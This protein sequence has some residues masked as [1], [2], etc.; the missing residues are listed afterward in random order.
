MT[1]IHENKFAFNVGNLQKGDILVFNTYHPS[2]NEK[3][4]SRYI[5]SALY[6][7][8]AFLL[9][10]DGFGVARNHIY[11]YGF[12]EIEDAVVL[13]VKNLSAEQV[14]EVI[15]VA[16]TKLGT[17]YGTLE[18]YRSLRY[19]ETDEQEHENRMFCSRLIA[20]S[21]EF[22]GVMLVPNPNYC[23]PKDFINSDKVEI[24]PDI[25]EETDA[26]LRKLIEKKAKEREDGDTVLALALLLQELREF[27][28]EDIQNMNQLNVVASKHPEKD[29]ECIQI[30]ESAQFFQYKALFYKVHPWTM[31][32]EDF[33]QHFSKTDDR[34]WFLRN[35]ISHIEKSYLPTF[36]NNIEVY[37]QLIKLFPQSGYMRYMYDGYSADVA[38]AKE[39][40]QRMYELMYFTIDEDQEGS[41]IFLDDLAT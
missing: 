28:G 16:G 31:T 2:L 38:E 1:E 8:D 21:F 11:S 37:S 17:E 35:Q 22:V 14:D 39:I 34:L 10:S 25:L 33:K 26:D 3:M 7:G 30:I 40:L 5:H 36:E 13:R 27:Y 29:R 41:K 12:R 19:R 18:A 24:I 23:A 32:N 6:A 9:E 15:R 20:K 4:Q